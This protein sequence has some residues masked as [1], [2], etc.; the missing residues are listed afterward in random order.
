MQM[1]PEAAVEGLYAA[2][3]IQSRDGMLAYLTDDIY[4]AQLISS[5]DVS[6]AGVTVG[7]DK[8]GERCDMVFRDWAFE[9]IVPIPLTVE[10]EIIRYLCDFRIRLR[11]TGDVLEGRMR[12]VFWCH[13]GRIHRI[14]E[15]HDAARFE[16]FMRLAN[17]PR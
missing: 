10:G 16:A 2:W 6:H 15:Y 13:G 1:G 17:A 12:S 11:R 14:E 4:F 9:R 3:T 5:D 8:F 7:K